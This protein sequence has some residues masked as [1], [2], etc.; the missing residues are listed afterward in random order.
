MNEN[1]P[2]TLAAKLCHIMEG[3]KNIPKNGYNSFHK[4]KYVTA[5]DAA[6]YVRQKM[7]E[8]KVIALPNV[9]SINTKEVKSMNDRGQ[10]KTNYITELIMKYTFINA[11]N[12]EETYDVS[13]AGHGADTLDKSGYKANTGVHKYFIMQSFM[14]GGDDDPEKVDS[15]PQTRPAAINTAKP[16]ATPRPADQL[17]SKAIPGAWDGKQ[18]VHGGKYVGQMWKD[19]PGDYLEWSR[20][21]AKQ[22]DTQKMAEMEINR[23]EEAAQPDFEA[24]N[25]EA[26]EEYLAD[27]NA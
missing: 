17:A 15:K 11:E 19:L 9:V 2:K 24:I 7:A 8:E 12:P 13:M 18:K 14:L 4:Y 16:M 23:R 21:N 1:K 10:E 22:K 20:H 6:E 26:H 25:D 5:A 3:C 27:K